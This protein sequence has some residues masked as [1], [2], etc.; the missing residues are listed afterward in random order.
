MQKMPI[1]YTL[2][3]FS[4]DDEMYFDDEPEEME[5]VHLPVFDDNDE[6]CGLRS[7]DDA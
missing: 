2:P 1:E 6:I 7:V 3:K 5:G 4:D